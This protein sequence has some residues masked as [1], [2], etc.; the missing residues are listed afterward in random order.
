VSSLTSVQKKVKRLK[1]QAAGG[2]KIVQNVLEFK[3]VCLPLLMPP[4]LPVTTLLGDPAHVL[5][6]TAPLRIMA[7]PLDAKDFSVS[8]ECFIGPQQI[9]W[10]GQLGKIPF[11][12][13]LHIDGKY[14]L[15]HGKFCQGLFQKRD[16]DPLPRTPRGGA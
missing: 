7:I 16:A 3:H 15:H 9:K 10:T 2:A 14:K 13:V 6:L 11:Q 12:F 4:T 5:A 8:G 1:V